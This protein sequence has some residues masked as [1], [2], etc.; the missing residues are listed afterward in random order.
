[1]SRTN[2]RPA[3][4]GNSVSLE[5]AAIISERLATRGVSL[6]T[7]TKATGIPR[8]SLRRKVNL[9]RG[10]MMSD[11]ALIATALDIAPSELFPQPL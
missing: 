5:V 10:I 3:H 9:G 7:L 6:R 4:S 11:L 1:M 8:E 2:E